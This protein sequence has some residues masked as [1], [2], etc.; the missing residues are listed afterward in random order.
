MPLSPPSPTKL[1]SHLY[2]ESA[3]MGH[4]ETKRIMARFERSHI[5]EI[6]HYKDVFNRHNQDFAIQSQSKNL[7]LARKEAPFLYEGSY[8]SDGFEFEHFFY[9]PSLLGC[10]YD[11][12][13]CYLQG[14]YNSANSVLF[15]NIEDF[16]D[17]LTPYLHKPTLVAIS[18]DTDTLAIEKLTGQS[19]RWIEY[20]AQTP[21]LHLEIRTK[22]AN[23]RAIEAMVPNERI[24]L[25]WTLSPQ[26]IIERYEHF[27]PSLEARLRAIKAAVE[28]GWQVRVCIDPVIF[29]EDFDAI[30]PE[31]VD[32]L[33]LHVKPDALYS[34]TFGSFRMSSQHLKRLKQLRRSDIAFYP[35]DVSE[36]IVTY[37]TAIEQHI[38]D[39]LMQKA[40]QYIP[41][42][43]IR[44]W[45]LQ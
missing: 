42:E 37:P 14:M 13:Y 33:F 6:P 4:P 41:K 16:F 3:V 45:Q 31:L 30:Y 43:R 27:A 28:S 25:A 18:Y 29:T 35:Y 24:V 19:R 39:V 17:A 26:K 38:L 9:T 23:F 44:T 15:V 12:D 32:T 2:I 22:S 21:N 11:C 36:G 7:I 5:I 34:L 8:Y 40:L 1:F 20:A 10:L